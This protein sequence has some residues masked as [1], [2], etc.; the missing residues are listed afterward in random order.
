MAS[1][2]LFAIIASVVSAA[3]VLQFHQNVPLCHAFSSVPK[4]TISASGIPITA[5]SGMRISRDPSSGKLTTAS[6]GLFSGNSH[7]QQHRDG[8][9][10][11]ARRGRE[12][13]HLYTR[14]LIIAI[15][16]LQT[17]WRRICKYDFYLCPDL[18]PFSNKNILPSLHSN[19]SLYSFSWKFVFYV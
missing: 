7:H 8:D 19:P 2:F 5:T 9:D 12:V 16:I 6:V 15:I 18:I 13:L 4:P 11:M 14:A 3:I 10:I 1:S 17:R